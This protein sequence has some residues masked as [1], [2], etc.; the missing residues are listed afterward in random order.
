MAGPLGSCQSVSTEVRFKVAK[1]HL[2]GA[3]QIVMLFACDGGDFHMSTT[4]IKAHKRIIGKVYTPN[5][6]PIAPSYSSNIELG[7]TPGADG[8][9]DALAF[10]VNLDGVVQPFTPADIL[11]AFVRAMVASELEAGASHGI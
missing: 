7:R 3:R 1:N 6:E 11:T 9:Q 4:F 2:T 8:A 10:V 5:G